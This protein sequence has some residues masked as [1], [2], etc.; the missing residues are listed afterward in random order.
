MKN[1]PVY[2][3]L[4]YHLLL[5]DI[6][7]EKYLKP[8]EID[9]SIDKMKHQDAVFSFEISIKGVETEKQYFSF[10]FLTRFKLLDAEWEKTIG[11]DD[12]LASILFPIA[13]PFIRQSIFAAT[14]DSLGPI[15]I[16]IIDL[17]GLKMTDSIKLIRKEKEDSK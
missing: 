13:F 3:Y 5:A 16:P 2:E 9:I 6:K 12:K 4:G 17:R 1:D 7:R 14:N 10:V 8:K 15:F 11:G